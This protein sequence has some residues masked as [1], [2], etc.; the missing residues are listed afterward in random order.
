MVS[1]KG[2]SGKRISLQCDLELLTKLL[3]LTSWQVRKAASPTRSPAKCRSIPTRSCTR[4]RGSIGGSSGGAKSSRASLKKSAGISASGG[5]ASSM[6]VAGPERIFRCWRTSA[7]PKALTYR[8]RRLIF[9]GPEAYQ[10]LS[11]AP[12][13]LCR[14]KTLHL[15]WSRGLMWLSISMMTS[16]G[17]RKCAVCCG[18]A[19]GR[20]CS[21]RRS[22]FF[23][24]CRTTSVIIDAVTQSLG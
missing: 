13:K 17:S 3:S 16:P 11:T 23:G 9:A 14:T 21:C 12:P 22:C 5:R 15:I 20:F 7:W 19:A 24:E 8:L 4:S 1:A 18:P 10:K 6:W 2:L